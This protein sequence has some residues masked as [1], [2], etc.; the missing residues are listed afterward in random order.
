MRHK[1]RFGKAHLLLALRQWKRDKAAYLS[2]TREK[3]E[4][5]MVVKEILDVRGRLNEMNEEMERHSEQQERAAA[6][7][8]RMEAM[9][10]SITMHLKVPLAP[11]KRLAPISNPPST[12]PDDVGEV[13]A[14][15][16]SQGGG[17]SSNR[18][19]IQWQWHGTDSPGNAGSSRDSKLAPIASGVDA[20][21][22]MD[23]DEDLLAEALPG[24]LTPAFGGLPGA[25]GGGVVSLGS[26]R[27]SRRN[28]SSIANSGSGTVV[29]LGRIGALGEDRGSP[30]S[31][32]DG[33]MP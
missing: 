20:P 19:G 6:R 33:D 17:G 29:P 5:A 31:P 3:S 12:S 9:L 21:S 11:A 4:V 10:E 8:K 22:S 13:K 27:G 1:S 7:M 14:T 25:S 23:A 2:L 26:G 32:D 18:G 28:L 24:G 16:G 30:A 15:P